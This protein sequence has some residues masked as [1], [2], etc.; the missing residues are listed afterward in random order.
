[1]TLDDAC[2]L[3][4]R[5][6]C[7]AMMR[8]QVKGTHDSFLDGSLLCPACL[9]LHGRAA[10]AMEPLLEE[11]RLS[12]DMRYRDAAEALFGWIEQTMSQ[13]DGSWKNDVDSDW[14]GITVFT[15]IMLEHVLSYYG[16]LLHED[17][18]N[19]IG[20]RL[21]KSADYLYAVAGALTRNNINYPLSNALALWRLGKYYQEEQYLRKSEELEALAFQVVTNHGLLYGEGVP[22]ERRSPK[23]CYPIDPG[24]DF[25]ETIPSLVEL[26][27]CKQD[28][29]LLELSTRL[30]RE[31]LRFLLPDGG[32]DNSWGTRNFK[33]TWWGSRTSD[34]PGEALLLLSKQDKRFLGPLVQNIR[35]MQTCM[36]QGLLAGGPDYQRAGEKTCV[37]H[38]FT[39]AKVLA[40]IIRDGGGK[41]IDFDAPLPNGYGRYEEEGISFYDECDTYVAVKGRMS[42]TITGYDWSYI[43]GGHASGGTISLLYHSLYGPILVAGMC[44]YFLKEKNNMQVPREKPNHV[45]ATPRLRMG[46]FSSMYDSRAVLQEKGGVITVQG[47]LTNQEGRQADKG[48]YAFTYRMEPDALE[49]QTEVQD[50]TLVLPIA[51]HSIVSHEAHRIVLSRGGN[52]VVVTSA[53]ELHLPFGE[54]LCFN[55]SPGLLLAPVEICVHG[56]GTVQICVPKEPK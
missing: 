1:M 40:A 28:A 43:P 35:A 26:A 19:T 15:S 10:D 32:I 30:M 17:V 45:C 37:H 9:K 51:C 39:H 7:D 16:D 22:R 52:E 3:M 56:T 33:W 4:L 24:Y 55:L 47:R 2:R 36:Q 13:P 41:A 54:E 12:G 31:Q 46:D 44:S 27:V 11:A 25:E 6:M 42:A 18:R 34:G 50:A 29:R 21:R 14:K 5:A 8:V 53:S 48:T 38:T 23:G 49:I 20:L